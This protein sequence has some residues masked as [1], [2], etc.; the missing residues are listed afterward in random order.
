MT[1]TTPEQ[2]ARRV[3]AGEE[4]ALASLWLALRPQL[5]P[6]WRRW[7]GLGA[8]GPLEPADL[9]QQAFLILDEL[10]RGWPGQGLF[11]AWCHRLL[12]CRLLSYRRAQLGFDR[13]P[14]TSISSL[15][16][17]DAGG[18]SLAAP[19]QAELIC[20]RQL[21][22]CLPLTYRR[23][24]AWRYVEGLSYREIERLF[25]LPA[26]TA[27]RECARAQAWLRAQAAGEPV[28]PLRRLAARA[29]RPSRAAGAAPVAALWALADGA[30]LLPPARTA[31]QALGLK[32]R[33]YAA[34]VATLREAGCLGA[35]SGAATFA[36][37]RGRR[38]RLL[39]SLAEAERRLA[40][41]KAPEVVAKHS[42]E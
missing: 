33:A 22:A 2:W 37:H 27:Q 16:E 25:G 35:P 9:E 7:Q 21:L 39:V 1:I 28:K 41:S 11:L 4:G 14:V 12:P 29:L 17:N 36:S 32:A 13:A 6:H 26:A 42:I 15:E 18:R 23:L 34:L 24:L 8:E 38:A 10:A 5:E 3:Q 20:C 19:D 40:G 31:A 30:G